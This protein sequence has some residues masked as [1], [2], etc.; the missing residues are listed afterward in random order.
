MIAVWESGLTAVYRHGNSGNLRKHC[1]GA[2]IIA[3][4][5]APLA[6]YTSAKSSQWKHD[7]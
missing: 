7:S 4:V 5:S 2:I 1:T 6:L 3:L